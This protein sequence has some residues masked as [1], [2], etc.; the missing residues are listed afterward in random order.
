[1]KIIYLGNPTDFDKHTARLVWGWLHETYGNR[2]LVVVAE[3]AH[4]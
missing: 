3:K 1:M 4:A 2:G